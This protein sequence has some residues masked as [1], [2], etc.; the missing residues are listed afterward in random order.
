M[1]APL[2]GGVWGG[3]RGPR[4]WRDQV[5]SA[6]PPQLLDDEAEE[7]FVFSLLAQGFLRMELLL[8]FIN[9]YCTSGVYRTVAF[10][11]V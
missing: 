2:P 11:S 6:Q 8:I 4:G 5:F 10:P 1:G 7:S 3:W 9:K